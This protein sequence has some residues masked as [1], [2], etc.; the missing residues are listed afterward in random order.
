MKSFLL[1][2]MLLSG[3]LGYAQDSYQSIILKKELTEHANAV[4]RDE[5]I[6]IEVEDVDKMTVTTKR[7][8]TV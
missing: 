3:I 1:G 8:V 2:F 5:T 6:L 7:V 4:I